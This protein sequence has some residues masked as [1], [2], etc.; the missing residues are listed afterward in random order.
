M[1]QRKHKPGDLVVQHHCSPN[2]SEGFVVV[3]ITPDLM[4]EALVGLPPYRDKESALLAACEHAGGA[5]VWFVNVPHD[6]YFLH[7]CGAPV[8]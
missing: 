6:D 8:S 5:A 2:G 3:K 1:E 7:H 4:A